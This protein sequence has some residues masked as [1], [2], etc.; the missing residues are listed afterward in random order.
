MSLHL[1]H[2]TQSSS[3][4]NAMQLTDVNFE[5]SNF[6][7]VWNAANT[8]AQVQLLIL[9][10]KTL[11]VVSPIN[12]VVAT[13]SLDGPEVAT[14]AWVRE[15]KSS[16]HSLIALGAE[17]SVTVRDSLTWAVVAK[18]EG[19]IETESGKIGKSTCWCTNFCCIARD[20]PA[21]YRVFQVILLFI[22]TCIFCFPSDSPLE[23]PGARGSVS[24]LPQRSQ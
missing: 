21:S 18:A 17:N 10:D 24:R 1:L 3:L 20:F 5:A 4:A 19:L 15:P 9:A 2:I 12:G 13:H 16:N 8:N 14:A 6:T 11:T 22:L 23:L 7:C